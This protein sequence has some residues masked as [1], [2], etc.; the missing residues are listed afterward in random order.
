VQSTGC[1]GEQHVV[2]TGSEDNSSGGWTD[3]SYSASGS[4]S[5]NSSTSTD[6]NNWSVTLDAGYDF[7]NHTVVS[8]VG[9]INLPGGSSKSPSTIPTR[10]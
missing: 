9:N 1:V 6:A 8:G 2:E 4:S 3:L 7:A 5:D 10:P